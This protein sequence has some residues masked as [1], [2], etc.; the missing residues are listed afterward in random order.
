[1]G[2]FCDAE[3]LRGGREQN[4][5]SNG[6]V[7]RVNSQPLT[8]DFHLDAKRKSAERA[9]ASKARTCS[10]LCRRVSEVVRIAEHGARDCLLATRC[11]QLD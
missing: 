8:S 7:L 3:L 6:Q 4:A 11:D 1:M 9:E 10:P 5:K 2:H